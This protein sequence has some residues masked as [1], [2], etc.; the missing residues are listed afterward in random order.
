MLAVGRR[1]TTRF[2]VS[3]SLRQRISPRSVITPDTEV[4]GLTVSFMESENPEVS[5][6]ILSTW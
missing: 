3:I 1:L 6:I 5:V 4:W 2:K